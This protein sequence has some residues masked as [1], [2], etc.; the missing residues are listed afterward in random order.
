MFV[1]SKINNKSQ[2]NQ[3]LLYL[4]KDSV[5]ARILPTNLQRIK[6][7]ERDFGR[8]NPNYYHHTHQT[9][10]ESVELNC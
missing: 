7:S 4:L 9:T 1:D 10:S 3:I 8:D 6:H 2:N 5:T